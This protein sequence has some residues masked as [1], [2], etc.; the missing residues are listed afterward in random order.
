MGWEQDP[1]VGPETRGLLPAIPGVPRDVYGSVAEDHPEARRDEV[2]G[3][4]DCTLDGRYSPCRFSDD[5]YLK[6]DWLAIPK[7]LATVSTLFVASVAREAFDSAYQ[8]LASP[9]L[10][11]RLLTGQDIS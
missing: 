5:V 4:A 1:A 11:T 10:I 3:D 2:C 6:G 9:W 7:C 8:L